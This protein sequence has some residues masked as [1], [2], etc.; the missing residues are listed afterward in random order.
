MAAACPTCR[1]QR[2]CATSSLA[3]DP[4]TPLRPPASPGAACSAPPPLASSAPACPRC[5]STPDPTK[6]SPSPSSSS[7]SLFVDYVGKN[8]AACV[9]V[10]SCGVE[11]NR[12]YV[13]TPGLGVT[14]DHSLE[15]MR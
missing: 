14:G 6:S 10:G 12:V 3:S 13:A 15:V 5:S 1:S 11:E 7:R 8:A 9:D 2:C 4:S